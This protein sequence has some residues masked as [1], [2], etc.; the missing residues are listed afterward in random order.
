MSGQ[1]LV[2]PELRIVVVK[3]NICGTLSRADEVRSRNSKAL[4]KRRCYVMRS[5]GFDRRERTE[6]D[7]HLIRETEEEL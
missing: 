5:V 2:L 3:E 7:F 4:E 1:T 6:F